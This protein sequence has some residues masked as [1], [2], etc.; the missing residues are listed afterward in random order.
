M[1][2]FFL[3]R[4]GLSFTLWDRWDVHGHKTFMLKDFIKH[5]KVSHSYILYLFGGVRM[6]GWE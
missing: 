1:I 2:S 4:E 5:F 6:M 3:N